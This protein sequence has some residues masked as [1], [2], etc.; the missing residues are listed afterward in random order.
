[1][2][3]TVTVALALAASSLAGSSASAQ[4]LAQR[5]R[6]AGSGTVELHY[7][8]RRGACGDG[9]RS[10]SI[11][12]GFHIG[13]WY[14]RDASGMLPACVPGPARV[15]L[16]LD[17]GSVTDVRVAVGPAVAHDEA[18][19]DLGAVSS[20]EAADYFL[21]LA[22]TSTT[23]VSHGAITAAVLADSATVW[24]RLLTIATD[25]SGIPRSTRHDALFWVG[26]FAAAKTT[27]DGEDLAA[28]GEADDDDERED[29]RKAAIFALSQLRGRGGIP[30]LVQIARS[31]RDPTLRRQAM[32]WLGESG[33]PRAIALFAEILRGG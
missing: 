11:G 25:S 13:E 22:D 2:R 31:H 24:R 21:R 3:A 5:V 23:R 18:A 8:A 30:Q 32:F 14:G 26:R 17:R 15:R 10:F 19:T 1:M 29:P 12:G 16:K 7:G 28:L 4:T 20:A 9:R 27:G 6:A 33:D